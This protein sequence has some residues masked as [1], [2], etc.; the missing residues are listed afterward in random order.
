MAKLRNFKDSS[1]VIPFQERKWYKDAMVELENSNLKQTN[2][3]IYNLTWPRLV[4]IGEQE[5]LEERQW[6]AELKTRLK[7]EKIDAQKW[8]IEYN[9]RLKKYA[10]ER[11][12]E[13]A[14]DVEK[15]AKD[16]EVSVEFVLDIQSQ[17]A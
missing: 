4:A 8:N 13:L 1:F 11:L 16:I 9:F 10:T 3:L 6:E 2:N 14:V 17:K 15:I 7:P 12:L 5:E